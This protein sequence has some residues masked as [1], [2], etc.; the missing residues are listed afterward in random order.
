M[1]ESTGGT[2]KKTTA[3]VLKDALAAKK[4]GGGQGTQKLR[5]DMGKGNGA[6]KD[7]ERLKGKS[8]KVH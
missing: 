6:S 5:P 2:K 4:A 1:A 3:D 8:R 7:A